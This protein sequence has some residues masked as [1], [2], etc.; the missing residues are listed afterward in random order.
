MSLHPEIIARKNASVASLE[1]ETIPEK[2]KS[3]QH[4]LV[5]YKPD[6]NQKPPEITE[7]TEVHQVRINVEVSHTQQFTD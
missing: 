4:L 6:S 2:P 5:P 7:M 3:P 1:I